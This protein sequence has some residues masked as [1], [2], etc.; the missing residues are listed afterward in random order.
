MNKKK[1]ISVTNIVR[2]CVQLAFFIL[3][4][5]LFAA[6]F[7]S[8]RQVMTGIAQ[9]SFSV[10]AYA[11]QSAIMI[12]VL[13]VTIIFGRIF[14]GWMCAFGSVGDFLFFLR[15]KLVKKKTKISRNLDRV[16][17]Y[18]KYAV[19]VS[20][21][22]SAWILNTDLSFADPW[23]VFGLLASVSVFSSIGVVVKSYLIGLI[24]LLGIFT[25]MF[26]IERFFCRY[27]CPL[28]AI[29]SLIST[30]RAYKIKKQ[31]DGCAK[32]AA[33]TKKCA[34]NIDL[35]STDSVASGE[36]IACNKCV[37]ICPSK[38]AKASFLGIKMPALIVCLVAVGMISGLYILGIKWA[39][40][41]QSE[42]QSIVPESETA[43]D[44]KFYDGTYSG[45]G[46]GYKGDVVL[47]VTVS[48]GN[49]TAI[50][51]D[52][53]RD[54]TQ[55]FSRA[56]SQIIPQVIAA[57]S[58]EVDAVSGATFSSRGITEAAADALDEAVIK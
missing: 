40:S 26:F 7:S 41:A 29:F 8:A 18:I 58:A 19:L 50:T 42:T 11:Y 5:G 15:T 47:T 48:G 33:C 30:P 43:S 37:D 54:D 16:L 22:V 32:C 9:G 6:V 53:Y 28:G 20:I 21:I 12:S 57:Q 51:I 24:L 34:M 13:P 49:V 23:T 1:R 4:P 17:K 52:S 36:C 44:A 56:A 55:Y 38:N 3:L 39:L 10:S 2:T 25:A 14:C 31:R 35:S 27:L 45:T 46:A